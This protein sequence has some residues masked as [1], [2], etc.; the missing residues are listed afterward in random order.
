MIHA[1]FIAESPH[2]TMEFYT[3]GD[4]SQALT[5]LQH[6]SEEA[7]TIITMDHEMP[8]PVPQDQ[9][10]YAQLAV[11]D[12]SVGLKAKLDPLLVQ[13]PAGP[14]ED[15]FGLSN[16]GYT[17][18][19]KDFLSD[20]GLSLVPTSPDGDCMYHAIRRSLLLPQEYSSSHL[21][22]QL[23]MFCIDNW[24][25]FMPMVKPYLRYNYG[26]ARWTAKYLRGQ[27]KLAREE[28]EDETIESKDYKV[29]IGAHSMPRR[30]TFQAPSVITTWLKH[31]LTRGTWGDPLILFL[32][33]CMWQVRI[34]T[35]TEDGKI[36]AYRHSM[37]PRNADIVIF[38][39]HAHYTATGQS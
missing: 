14:F 27:R 32:V 13:M 9:W 26:H 6:T 1:L 30:R 3:A 23:V 4:V 11:K 37:P 34:M 16:K 33:S 35:I 2:T 29:D 24:Q 15:T 20:H 7:N 25:V 38:H 31:I 17:K 21:R 18:V 22:R 39:S 28:R 19:V 12:W 36:F 8:M 5:R 10:T